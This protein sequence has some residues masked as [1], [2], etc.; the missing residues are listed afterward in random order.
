[1]YPPLKCCVTQNTEHTHRWKHHNN[2]ISELF[3]SSISLQALAAQAKPLS[4]S[5]TLSQLKELDLQQGQLAWLLNS[6]T[7]KQNTLEQ[8]FRSQIV[9]ICIW[10]K[11]TYRKW[12]TFLIKMMKENIF[13]LDFLCVSKVSK[14]KTGEK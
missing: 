6:P 12:A 7:Q 9:I 11:Y 14:L 13:F 4:S 1:M 2:L 5:T 8:N 10:F 3:A